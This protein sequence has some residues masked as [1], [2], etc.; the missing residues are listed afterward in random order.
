[1]ATDQLSRTFAALADP[2]RREILTRLTKG[3]ATVSELAAPFSKSMPA[4][5]RHLKVLESAGLIE[6]DR[7]A[8][9][10]PSRLRVEPLGG[11]SEWIDE[12][13]RT[14]RASFD[15]L[16][17]HLKSLQEGQTGDE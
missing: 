4:I 13:R 11:A 6:R 15:R 3:D 2:T 17:T 12:R 9:Y 16:D 14:W 5:S 8:Q 1:M 7:S 10:R